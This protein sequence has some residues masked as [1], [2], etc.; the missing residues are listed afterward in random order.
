M[1][2][3]PPL[4]LDAS[5]PALRVAVFAIQRLQALGRHHVLVLAHIDEDD[6]LCR[7]AGDADVG[8]AGAYQLALVG[9]Q[10]QLL[11][12]LYRER[13]DQARIASEAVSDQA[14]TAAIGDTILVS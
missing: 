1:R 6:P 11:A 8:H 7:P 12:V 2:R 3:N 9:H 5:L 4:T 13:G 10:Q 14:L